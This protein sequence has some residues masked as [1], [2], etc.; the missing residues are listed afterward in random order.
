MQGWTPLRDTPPPT[1][2]PVPPPKQKGC[3][4]AP[5]SNRHSSAYSSRPETEVLQSY[6]AKNRDTDAHAHVNYQ[7]PITGLHSPTL[8]PFLHIST[9][10]LM[11]AQSCKFGVKCCL[12]GLTRPVACARPR[13]PLTFGHVHNP[14]A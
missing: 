11:L 6:G 5:F 12:I 13:V 14:L 7:A 4:S 8:L 2:L 9:D 10:Y 1:P 3:Q